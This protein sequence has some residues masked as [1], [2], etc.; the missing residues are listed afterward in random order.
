MERRHKPSARRGKPAGK[1]TGGVGGALDRSIAQRPE[2][3]SPSEQ[4]FENAQN[5]KG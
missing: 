3:R 2:C 5:G 4:G 1:K